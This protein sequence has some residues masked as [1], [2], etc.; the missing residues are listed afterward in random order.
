MLLRLAYLAMTHAFALLRQLPLS[1]RDRDVEILA[2][3]HHITILEREL[4]KGRPRFSPSDRAFLAA[5]LHRLP[6]AT[7]HRLRL[8]VRPETGLRWHRDLI[9]RHHA[10]RSRPKRVPLEKSSPLVEQGHR[11]LREHGRVIV[12]LLY[13]V[14]RKLLSVP[15][16]LLRS[17]AAKNAELLVLR[18]E[19]AVLRRQ[20][21]SPI[22][23]EPADRLWFAALSGLVDR[24]RWRE[25]FP[26]TPGTLLAW[27][28]KL[29]ARKWG[30]SARRRTGRPPTRAAVKTLVLRLARE[31]PRWGHRRIQGELARLGHRIACS[32]VWRIL[33]DAGIDPAPRR[34]GP[35]WRQFPTALWGVRTLHWDAELRRS[36]TL[37]LQ[38]MIVRC[39]GTTAV[40]DLRPTR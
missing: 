27:H 9:A 12:S 17:Q 25:V 13:K 24:R 15:A 38:G 20:L 8:L 28:R 36:G 5:L 16:V 30:H 37:D 26:V 11:R 31:N 34:G 2:L 29:I 33:H 14:T 39:G 40:P 32:T 7:L 6:V 3:R 10:A 21:A 35:T 4:G 23:Y 1:D 19:N 18:H 22:R